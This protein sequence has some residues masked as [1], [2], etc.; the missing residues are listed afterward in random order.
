MKK[1]MSFSLGRRFPAVSITGARCALACP[2][3]AGR[4]LAS[5]LDADSPEKLL[6]IAARLEQAGAIGFLLSGG[7]DLDGKLPIRPYLRAIREIKDRGRLRINAH[8]GYPRSQDAAD[9]VSSGIDVFSLNF[10][11]NDA[12]GLRTTMVRNAVDRYFETYESLLDAGAQKVVPHVLIGLAD[13]REEIDGLRT[14]CVR[15]PRAIVVIAFTPLLGTPMYMAQPP[16]EGHIAEFIRNCKTYLP[17][18][19]LILG[20]MR[21]RGNHEMELALVKNWIDGI[22]MPSPRVMQAA[23]ESVEIEEYEGCCAL[24]L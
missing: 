23:R 22:V 5:M 24:Y 9:L 17:H 8:I 18:T 4:P 1:V 19:R 14:L 15:P 6:A 13:V 21:K 11:I 12:L 16:D 10:P 7:C 3:C 20:C 2:H